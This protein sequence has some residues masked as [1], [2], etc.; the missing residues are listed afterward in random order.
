LAHREHGLGRIA[1]PPVLACERPAELGLCVF[2]GTLERRVRPG[3]N[4][5]HEQTRAAEP[6][7]VLAP[8]DGERA[9]TVVVPA[10][11]PAADDEARFG[12]GV[13]MDAADELHRDW[14]GDERER[15]LRVLRHRLPQQEP[16]RLDHSGSMIA[17]SKAITTSSRWFR[18]RERTR[19]IP[20]PGRDC[21][22]RFETTSVSARSV[23]PANAGATTRTS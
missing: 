15:R 6:A 3:A 19:T 13:G 2:A 1:L 21:D 4:V 7:P 9:A 12:A 5:P 16:F 14:V 20:E 10:F 11:E 22:F 18:P 8:E 17:R 23:S